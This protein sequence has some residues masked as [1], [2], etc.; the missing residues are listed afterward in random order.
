MLHLIVSAVCLSFT[1][2][3]RGVTASLLPNMKE[4]L[5]AVGNQNHTHAHFYLL[6][7]TELMTFSFIRSNHKSIIIKTHKCFTLL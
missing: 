4:K 6:F 2:M 1:L 3:Q 7:N 5:H